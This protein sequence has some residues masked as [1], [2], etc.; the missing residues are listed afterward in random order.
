MTTI[1]SKNKDVYKKSRLMYLWK[2]TK[3]KSESIK[4]IPP[5]AMLAII[6]LMVNQGTNGYSSI[7]FYFDYPVRFLNYLTFH[8]PDITPESRLSRSEI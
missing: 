3:M 1:L 8:I 4:I 7:L 2:M 6:L 5:F